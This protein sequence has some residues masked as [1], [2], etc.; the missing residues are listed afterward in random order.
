MEQ[1]A[2]SRR[3]FDTLR[4]IS[5]PQANPQP[6]AALSVR[7]LGL[8]IDWRLSFRPAATKACLQ[9]KRTTAA[10]HRLTA[11]GQGISQ[12]AALRLYNAA[13]LGAALYALPLVTVR[14][15]CWRK[16]ETQHRKSLRVCLGLPKN[17]QS[18]ATLAEAGAWPLQL[19]ATRRA[20]HHIDRLHRAPDGASLLQRLRSH[21]HSRMGAALQEYERLTDAAPPLCAVQQLTRA[22]IHEELRDYLLV[23]TDGS[24][25]RDSCSLA[26]AAT[27]PALRLHS[28]T[29]AAFLGSSTTAELL[30]LQL[31]VDL[32]LTISPPPPRSALLCD[33]RS[34]R[35]R[36][37]CNGRGTPLVRAICSGIAR[38]AQ[39]GCVVR[40][41]WV[42]GHCGIAGNEEA[43]SLA[44]A[45]HQLP[46]SD[47]PL[48]L[49]DVR[50]V[51]QEDLRQQHPDPR[52]AGGE[53][54]P[55]LNGCRALSRQ[56][57]AM[58]LRARV[59]CVWPGVRRVR[60]GI[61]TSDVCDG[62]GAVET[63]EHLLLRCTAFADARRDML[64]AYRALGIF[65]D[66]LE[67]LLWPQ[68]SA[69][70]RERTLV[71][72]CVFLE[73]AGLTSRLFCAR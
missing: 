38:L 57:R 28:Q 16:L 21:P 67:T 51:I 19:Q 45:A 25:V 7:Y 29:H 4:R 73:Q 68:G 60:H 63:M 8:D 50:A 14:K 54:I 30:G 23:Y 32:L 56:Q 3:L 26:A 66:S 17:S 53:R 34:A 20:L 31:G 49:E 33:S 47:H 24:V 44:T 9:L 39:Q 58:I 35:T 52:I 62:C 27:I 46:A 70:T 43:D 55:S 40:A 59:G 2:S 48:S 71:S 10:V 69:R 5:E 41:Q 12:H 37:Q 65:P 1:D 36:L 22:V 72:L 64:A 18:A 6:L 11:R 42:P 13:A 61:A 15:P